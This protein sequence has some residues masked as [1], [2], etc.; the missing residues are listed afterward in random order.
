MKRTNPTRAITAQDL[1]RQK[2]GTINDRVVP[3]LRFEI[4]KTRRSFWTSPRILRPGG[5]QRNIKVCAITASDLE[6]AGQQLKAARAAARRIIEDASA[7]IDPAERTRIERRTAQRAREDTF[8]AFA[9]L[10]MAEDG[11]YKADAGER[12]RMLEKELFPV[13]GDW[14]MRDITRLQVKEYLLAKFA[15][16]PKGSEAR[17]IKSLITRIFGHALDEGVVDANVTAG[18]KLPR[19]ETPRD[20]YLKADEIRRFWNGL[21]DAVMTKQIK[22]I[23]RLLLVTGQRRGEVVGLHWDELD[24]EGSL[25]ELPA[26]RTKSRRANRVPLTPLAWEIIHATGTTDG[27]VFARAGGEPPVLRSISQAMRR[28]LPALGLADNPATPHDLRRTLASQMGELGVE[29]LILKK[30]LNHRDR[31]ITGAVYELSE[32]FEQRRWAMEAWSNRLQE[33]VGDRP[34]PS[35]VTP[36]R[37]VQ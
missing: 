19:P 24:V 20:R 33:I 36:L 18:I 12:W 15:A 16:T 22:L 31:D 14:P 3:G 5:M 35:V 9:R 34:V 11:N 23:L 30:L 26:A 4:S 28:D 13:F 32:K 17:H 6:E 29:R 37:A 1:L 10:Y 7:G 27:Y 8:E 21:D 25:W 2:L